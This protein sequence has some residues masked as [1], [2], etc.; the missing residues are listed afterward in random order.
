[1]SP[2]PSGPPDKLTFIDLSSHTTGPTRATALSNAIATFQTTYG[3]YP[4]YFAIDS[5]ANGA[6]IGAYS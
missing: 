1:M 6:H 5:L 2:T 4:Q 3:I